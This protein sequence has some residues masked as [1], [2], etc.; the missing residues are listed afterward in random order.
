MSAI[1][2]HQSALVYIMVVASVAD[3]EVQDSELTTMRSVAKSLPIFRGYNDEKM[4]FD[5]D[6][7]LSMLEQEDGLD[8][9]LTLIK[10]ALPKKLYRTA[11]ILACD[12]V[13]CDGA[14]EDDELEWLRLVRNKLKLNRLEAGAIELASCARFV[15]L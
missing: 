12:V 6:N 2:N 1:L 4:S 8:I 9:V 3:R 10:E 13:T 11:Y 7:C 5:I 14:T 15:R